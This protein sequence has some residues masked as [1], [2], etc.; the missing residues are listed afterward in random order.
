MQLKSRDG[1][2]CDYCGTSYRLEFKYY[3]FDFHATK[4]WNN[5]KQP[6]QTI[7]RTPVIASFDICSSCYS[8]ISNKIVENFQKQSNNRVTCEFDGTLITGTCDYFY[9]VVTEA[10]VKISNSGSADILTNARILEMIIGTQAYN[11]FVNK[12]QELISAIDGWS[13]DS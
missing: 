12:K 2:S 3:S 7:L 6:I 4:L 11:H 10:S 5:V 8:E 9:C 1:I 13:T